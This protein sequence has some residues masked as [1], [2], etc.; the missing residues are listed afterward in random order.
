MKK[1]LLLALTLALGVTAT[2]C[3]A[4]PFSDVPAGH[5]AYDSINQLV[6]AGVVEGYGDATFGGGRLMTRY[7]MAQIVARAMAQGANVDRL[8]AEF[9][10]ELDSLGVR[11]AKLEKKSDNVQITGEI[12]YKY[13]STDYGYENDLR[14]R[15]WLTGKAN[16]DWSY[17]AMVENTQDFRDN[18]ENSDTDFKSAYVE[19]KLGGV[20]VVAGRYNALFANGNIYDEW[21]DGG[22][23][24]YGNKYKITGF[25][26]KAS[27]ELTT[28]VEDGT[29]GNYAGGEV[30]AELGEDLNVAV[31]Y[32]N[33]KDI[34]GVSGLDDAIWYVGADLGRGDFSLSA[35]YLNG[36]TKHSGE[37]RFAGS[38]NG[39][40]V[41]LAYLGA[42]PDEPGSWGIFFDYYDQGGATYIAHTTDANVF[43]GQ[44]FKGYGIGAN[45][46]FAK[47]FVATIDYY[48]TKNKLNSSEKDRRIWTDLTFTF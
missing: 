7:E 24:S 1:S 15:I 33:Y 6:A 13:M 47:N 41:E 5:W 18:Y 17:T 38:K 35:M 22:E 12:R 11:V 31:G 3:A 19:G 14:S 28:I 20:N 26:G 16:K 23:L 40:T 29:G 25:A 45:Y 21:V 30:S 48:T 43:D 4:N 39:Y 36:K 46:A 34:A 37:E 10:E 8:A 2:A 27:G 32:I 44:G 9:A 42:E